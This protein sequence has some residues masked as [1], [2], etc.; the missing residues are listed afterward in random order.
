M[1]GLDTAI[2]SWNNPTGDYFY[3][4]LESIDSTR[5]L[6]R[7]DTLISRRFVSDPTNQNFCTINNNSILYTGKYSLKVYRVN[8]EYADLY[9]SREQDSRT[10]NEPLTNVKNGLGI[11]AAFAS[12][13]LYFT[14]TMQQP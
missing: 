14:A 4:V 1:T 13:T 3:I 6:L 5:Q 2:V 9:K 11:F 10:L 8:R 7:A 12:D